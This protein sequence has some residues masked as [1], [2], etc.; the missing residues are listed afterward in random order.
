MNKHQNTSSSTLQTLKRYLLTGILVTAPVAI[1]FYL[2]IQL[3]LVVDK[4]ILSLIPE[5]YH[6]ATYL[7]YGLPGLGVLLLLLG[8]IF[9]GWLTAHWVGRT[10]MAIGDYLIAKMPIISGVYSTF[11]KIFETLFGAGQNAAFRHPVLIEYPRKG[12]WTIAFLTGPVY[13][14]IQDKVEDELVSV[15]VPTTPNP[16]S[17]FLIYVPQ[18]DVIALN[19]S[20]DEALKIVLSTGIVNPEKSRKPANH[21]SSS[22]KTASSSQKRPSHQTVASRSTPH[23][24]R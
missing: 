12:L 16:T 9:I 10:M 15:Y 3:F 5:T 21:S 2:A 22:T 8:L 14:G 13:D 18:K 7:P 24:V 23:K 20:V 1:T 17:G 11:R 4:N 19:L 6:P